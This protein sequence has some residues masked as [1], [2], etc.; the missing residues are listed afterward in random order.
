MP[1][2]IVSYFSISLSEQYSIYSWN[3]IKD[4]LPVYSLII[5]FCSKLSTDSVV[6]YVLSAQNQEM[7][8]SALIHFAYDSLISWES[9]TFVPAVYICLEMNNLLI[10]VCLMLHLHHS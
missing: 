8:Y 10:H 4:S 9:I 7:F 1:A 5:D 6:I 3:N 2:N